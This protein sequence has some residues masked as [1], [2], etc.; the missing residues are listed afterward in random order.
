MATRILDFRSS[1]AARKTL[2]QV[3]T[4]D[5]TCIV[6]SVV[7]VRASNKQCMK[8]SDTVVDRM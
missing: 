5:C 2:D 4:W 1:P 8:D 7:D 3:R 6:A